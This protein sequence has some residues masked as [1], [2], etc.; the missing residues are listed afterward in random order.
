MSAGRFFV[1]PA[2][3]ADPANVTLPPAVAAQVR[4]V[5]R[6]TAGDAITLLDGTGL[7][8]RTELTAVTRDRITARVVATER[9]TTEPRVHLTLCVGLLKAAKFEWIVQKGT[10]LGVSA[11]VPLQCARSVSEAVSA[12]KLARWHVIATEAAE[13]SDRAR[14][15]EVQAPVGFRESLGR[16]GVRLIAGWAADQ[17]GTTVRATLAG[18]EATAVNLWIGPEGGFA[19]EEMAAAQA[20]GLRPV[21]LG[22]RVLRAETAAIVAATLALDALG[23]LN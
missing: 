11:F 1:P 22:P 15:P 18:S 6:L 2:V 17:Q 21:I 14:V 5:L 10:E 13:Q 3:L 9:P 20:A 7:A 19:P 8:H 4:T 12:A 23:E 16:D